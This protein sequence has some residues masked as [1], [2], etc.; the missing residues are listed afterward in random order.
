MKTR[1]EDLSQKISNNTQELTSLGSKIEN[2][3]QALGKLQGNS[4]TTADTGA[5]VVDERKNDTAGNGD[6]KNVTTKAPE[7]GRR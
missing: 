3:A 6:S 2:N 4:E 7:A 1:L 5:K